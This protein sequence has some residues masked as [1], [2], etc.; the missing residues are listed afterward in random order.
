MTRDRRLCFGTEVLDVVFPILTIKFDGFRRGQRVALNAPQ[1]YGVT[2]RMR[3]GDVKRFYSADFTKVVFRSTGPEGV[4][5]E[6]V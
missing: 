1:I 2:L 4:E 3:T 6:I 5:A